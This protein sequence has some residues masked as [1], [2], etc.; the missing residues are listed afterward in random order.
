MSLH[1]LSILH[2]PPF[3]SL[4]SGRARVGV[5]LS[6]FFSL[7]SGRVR[8]G[9]SLPPWRVR[10]GVFL[11]ILLLVSCTQ[12]KESTATP[13][14]FQTEILLPTT[15]V[16]DQGN[17]S[18]CW[19]YA[20]LATIET[21][22]IVQGD[23]LNL[24][25]TFLARHLLEDQLE[26]IYLSSTPDKR[27]TVTTRGMAGDALS[28][29]ETYGAMPYD[30]WHDRADYKLLCRKLQLMA[31][32]AAVHKTGLKKL[33]DDAEPLM[34]QQMGPKKGSVY[35]LG[36]EYTPLEFAH[37]LFRHGE[38]EALTSFTH[39]PYGERITL[40]VPDNR[41]GNTMLNVPLDTLEARIVNAL[42][43]GHPVCWEGDISNPGFSYNRG[44]ASTDGKVDAEARQKAFEN[45]QTTDDHCMAIVGLARDKQGKL[46]FICKNSW[47]TSNPYNGFIYMNEAYLR[48]N[49]LAVWGMFYS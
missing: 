39:H 16:K 42:R 21:E 40:E 44:T 6:S 26:H 31:K 11:S 46:Y 34:N 12:K 13:E 5:S 18:L 22:H 43:H 35:M 7:P 33:L 2:H 8:V 4:P 30:T 37:S 19:A 49:T 14:T 9:V 28:L 48:I 10:V 27:A 17:S 20:M 23:S 15:P 29:M 25:T 38:Y 32:A 47:G 36:A 24:S 41:Y 45:R 3:F 1:P